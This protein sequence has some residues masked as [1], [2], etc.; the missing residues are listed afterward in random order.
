[1]GSIYLDSKVL[2][3]SGVSTLSEGPIWVSEPRNMFPLS[4]QDRWEGKGSQG[5]LLYPIP[6]GA[7]VAV[8]RGN[9][10]VLGFPLAESLMEQFLCPTTR[11]VPFQ[12]PHR[13]YFTLPFLGRSLNK[14]AVLFSDAGETQGPRSDKSPCGDGLQCSSGGKA[15]HCRAMWQAWMLSCALAVEGAC[16]CWPEPIR[17]LFVHLAGLPLAEQIWKLGCGL[18]VGWG[19]SE[20]V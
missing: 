13:L 9:P 1:M 3:R 16:L 14:L 5:S 10:P 17:G 20:P 2:L 7:G 4:N 19:I 8:P 11:S 6:G 12:L 18:L 15:S